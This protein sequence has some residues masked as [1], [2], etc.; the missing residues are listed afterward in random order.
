VLRTWHRAGSATPVSLSKGGGFPGAAEAAASCPEGQPCR[1]EH[2]VSDDGG[3]TLVIAISARKLLP[4]SGPSWRRRWTA[5]SGPLPA[6][7]G[8]PLA[9]PPAGDP[10]AVR[11]LE[12]RDGVRW[13]RLTLAGHD[14]CGITG[15][16]RLQVDGDR[17][18][19][20]TLRCGGQ[21]WHEGG[22]DA[23]LAALRAWLRAKALSAWPDASV[24]DRQL[25]LDLLEEDPEAAAL[26]EELLALP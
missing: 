21:P 26:V 18:D 23:A 4:S 24:E 16:L 7:V 17:A 3:D 1:L 19:A 22:S 5:M 12:E 13:W 10:A 25:W 11:T 8:D 20:R 6:C 15:V 14:R 2:W 9:D